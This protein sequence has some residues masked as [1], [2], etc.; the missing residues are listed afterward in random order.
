MTGRGRRP[1]LAAVLNRR[2]LRRRASIILLAVPL[3]VALSACTD[4]GY[5]APDRT[6]NFSD[7]LAVSGTTQ[8]LSLD[9]Q[10]YE[11]AVAD[12]AAITEFDATEPSAYLDGSRPDPD[13]VDFVVVCAW[14]D[15]A[16]AGE[17]AQDDA[18]PFLDNTGETG[19]AGLS[20]EALSVA[21]GRLAPT[22]DEEER[23]LLFDRIT[24]ERALLEELAPE[25]A[26][27]VAD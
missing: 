8:A 27:A 9:A 5:S 4:D 20:S 16:A 2:P 13:V 1:S 7:V 21:V 12:L 26:E 11:Q 19:C 22:G 15:A 24:L 6:V 23:A 10:W 14:A 25:I 18:E 3:V 17:L